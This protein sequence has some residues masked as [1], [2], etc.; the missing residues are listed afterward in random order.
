VVDLWEKSQLDSAYITNGIDT[1]NTCMY[2]LILGL[3][4]AVIYNTNEV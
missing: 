1:E 2:E 4:T 3:Y